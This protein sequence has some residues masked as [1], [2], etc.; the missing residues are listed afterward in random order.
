MDSII[1][2][3]RR[4][5]LAVDIGGTK[6][7]VGL[8]LAR[9]D[10]HGRMQAM[11][12][13]L[14][15]HSIPTGAR[16]GGEAVLKRVID[17]MR[18]CL[19]AGDVPYPLLGIGVAS[20]GVIDG[21]G[22]VLSATSLIP[23]WTGMRLRE[24]ISAA[25]DLP[26]SVVG[27]VQAHALGE[28]LWGCGRSLRSLLVAALGTGIGGA[29]IVGGELVRGAHGAC[30]HIGH[31]PHPDARGIPCS[32][33]R[34][35]HVEPIASGIG[36]A[37]NYRRL[38][39]REGRDAPPVDGGEVSALAARGDEAA[40]ASLVL[41]GHAIGDVLGG[42]VNAVDPDA[43]VLSGSVVRS[44]RCWMDAVNEGIRRQTLGILERT[45]VLVGTL[46]SK[47]PLIGAAEALCSDRSN[48]A[49]TEETS[50]ESAQ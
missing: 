36:I 26:V 12:R 15:G 17:A 19:D 24:A 29:L 23:G 6:I 2:D 47:A 33:G 20:A 34:S 45:P 21:T 1:E 16:Q 35:G 13:M 43:V 27:D 18:E 10:G 50:H 31:M 5:I 41:A 30:G 32:C 37:D 25:F 4:T 40:R 42:L 28:A 14:R 9:L 38:M 7:A 22:S 3:Q 11:P 8:M 44:G 39:R 48:E 49:H 46:G